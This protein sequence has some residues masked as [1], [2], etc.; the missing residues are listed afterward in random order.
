M[1][2]TVLRPSGRATKKG[3]L[4]CYQTLLPKELEYIFRE[5][6]WNVVTSQS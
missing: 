3:F 4:L 2:L 5:I 6:I 1:T